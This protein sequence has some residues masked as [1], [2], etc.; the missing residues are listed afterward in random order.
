MTFS[1]QM[2]GPL[3]HYVGLLEG[4]VGCWIHSMAVPLILDHEVV[5]VWAPPL[6]QLSLVDW[7]LNHCECQ[8][9]LLPLGS[10]NSLVDFSSLKIQFIG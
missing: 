9:W 6:G 7:M 3:G 10:E 5:G 8:W 4:K 2:D 1:Y